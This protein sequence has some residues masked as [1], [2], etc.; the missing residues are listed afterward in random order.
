MN[1]VINLVNFV[2]GCEPRFENKGLY[3]SVAERIS[4]NKQCGVKNTFLLQYDALIREDFQ[5]LFL[6]E[7]DEN[8]ELGIWFEIVRPLA[9]KVGIA[10]RGR[11]GFDWDWHVDPGFLEAYTQE[12]RRLLIDEA[13]RL[14]YEVFGEYPRVAGSWLMDAY[15]MAYMSDR[16]GMDAFCICREQYAVDAYTL[17]GGYYSGGYYPSQNNMICPAQHKETQI[18]TPVF[19]MLGI[20]PIYGY[21][22]D[23][24]DLRFQGCYTM[25]PCWSSGSDEEVMEWYFRS[26]Y[27]NPSLALSHATTG[28]ENSFGWSKV[29][30]GYLLQ[31]NLIRKYMEKGCVKCKT[32]GE[33]GLDFKKR[34]DHTP[35]SA[36]SAFDDWSGNGNQSVWYSCRNYRANLYFKDHTLFFR[37]IHEF[38]DQCQ[39]DHLIAPC[40]EWQAF[41]RTLPIVDSRIQGDEESKSEIR[42]IDSVEKMESSKQLSESE[43]EVTI[44]FSDGHF[45]YIRFDEETIKFYNCGE[46]QMFFGKNDLLKSIDYRTLHFTFNKTDYFMELSDTPVQKQNGWSLSSG[47]G[48]IEFLMTLNNK[49]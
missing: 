33:T 47:S 21:E 22:E 9:E 35:A 14:F 15:S 13:F 7:R 28:Q 43:L 41:Y 23:R 27:T 36:L 48:E 34:F 38:N 37:D 42:F 3:S 25:E 2:R 6:H 20:D 40:T 45:G 49:L 10:W 24:T 12:E 26:Y 11:P 46:L 1:N 17:W 44:R 5:N 32:L 18:N 30:K 16:Y 4:I 31:I 19:R 29:E 8:M 39:E